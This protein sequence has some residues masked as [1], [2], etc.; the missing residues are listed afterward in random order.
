M[1]STIVCKNCSREFEG[2]FCP[3]CG[4]KAKTSRITIKQVFNDARQ[5]F[6]HF[7]QGFLYTIK[8][9]MLRPGHTVREYI[10]G[11]RVKHIR[12]VKFM[13]WSAAISFLVFH[14]IGLDKDMMEKIGQQQHSGNNQLGQRFAEKVFSL[15]SEHPAIALFM[16]IPLIALWSRVL[17]RRY[18]YNYAEHFVLNAYLMG[19]ISLATIVTSPLAKLIGQF[20]TSTVPMTLFSVGVWVGYFAWAYGQFF[21]RKTAGTWIK[22][23]LAILLG[24]L[25]MILFIGLTV[26]AVILLFREQLEAWLMAS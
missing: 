26:T 13:F 7:D 20:T 18:Q 9:L 10:E 19:E 1:A 14:F 6:I 21:Q 16:M 15:F 5:H 23:G 12:P 8:A 24:Y 2:K 22:G 25:S 3:K 17:F 4:Q 11:K